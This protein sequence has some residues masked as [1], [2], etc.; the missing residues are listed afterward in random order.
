MGGRDQTPLPIHCQVSHPGRP[1]LRE[2]STPWDPTRTCDVE[3][4]AQG[5]TQAPS[6]RA[7]VGLVGEQ[8]LDGPE[9]RHLITEGQT[10]SLDKW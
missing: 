4:W 2:G 6:S 3:M 1:R 5:W 10:K 9:G 8:R 7:P